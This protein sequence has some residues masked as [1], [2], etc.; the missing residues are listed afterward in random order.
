MRIGRSIQ[1]VIIPLALTPWF[2]ILL[3]VAPFAFSGTTNKLMP[4]WP[5]P[6]V[7]TA[8]V[9][10]SHQMPFV[11]HF[12]LPKLVVRPILSDTPCDFSYHSRYI[13]HLSSPRL[14]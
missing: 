1:G 9:Q 13:Y 10:K 14:F 8:A 2:S 7:L 11:I 4:P 6:P 12:L 5:G 3:V